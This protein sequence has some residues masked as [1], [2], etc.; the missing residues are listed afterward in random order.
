MLDTNIHEEALKQMR[1][2]GGRWA[3]YRNVALD[4]A[5]CGHLRFLAYGEG[6][7]Y[8]RPPQRYP[9]SH[10]GTGWAYYYCGE[11]DL[12]AGRVRW[13]ANI[14]TAKGTNKETLVQNLRKADPGLMVHTA[15]HPSP[16]EADYARRMLEKGNTYVI[17]LPD[18]MG[19]P[20]YTKSFQ[21]AKEMAKEYGAETTVKKTSD[22]I[23][24]EREILVET[25]LS[26]E[27]IRTASGYSVERIERV[28]K[29]V[30]DGY[31][32]V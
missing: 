11:V 10:L 24:S 25:V 31:I 15:P 13:I 26:E 30:H 4:S 17:L 23:S 5:N 29:E 27:E 19:E 3:A 18:G 20:L 2:M 14:R 28:N 16:S 32:T 6:R 21:A 1:E 22:Y 8:Q 7:T 9:D 12:E